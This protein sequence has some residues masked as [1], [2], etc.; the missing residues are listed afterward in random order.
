MPSFTNYK[1]MIGDKFKKL[2][3]WLWS[4]PF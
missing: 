2:V 4:R 1:D 3:T